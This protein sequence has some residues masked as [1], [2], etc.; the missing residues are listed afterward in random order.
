VL[1]KWL[2][3]GADVLIFDE[4]T[5]G[6]DV[7]T[8]EEVYRIMEQ[9]AAQRRGVLFISSEFSELVA[10]CHRALVL[11]EGRLVGELEDAELTE[12][13]MIDRCYGTGGALVRGVPR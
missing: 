2:H 7:E 4:P 5:H 1:A 10:V 11:R 3:R 13:A 12:E 8:K 6:V 9:L